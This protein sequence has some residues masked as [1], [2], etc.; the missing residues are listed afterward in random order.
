MRQFPEDDHRSS[1]PLLIGTAGMQPT[2][3][4]FQ[5]ATRQAMEISASVISSAVVMVFDTAW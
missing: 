5:E 3:A 2:L 1:A 4:K